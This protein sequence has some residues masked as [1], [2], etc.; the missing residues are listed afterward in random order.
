M[1]LM[2][3][4]SVKDASHKALRNGFTRD[5]RALLETLHNKRENEEEV[6]LAL[7]QCADG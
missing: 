3:N 1:G 4:S 7:A 2:R 5:D 6:T